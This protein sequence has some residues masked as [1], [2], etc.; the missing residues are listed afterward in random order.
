[1]ILLIES[2]VVHTAV[3]RLTKFER[4][5]VAIAKGKRRLCWHHRQRD[6]LLNNS[7]RPHCIYFHKFPCH[8]SIF[9][10]TRRQAKWSRRVFC[11]HVFR[12]LLRLVVLH[13]WPH[14]QS[15]PIWNSSSRGCGSIRE[16]FAKLRSFG[17]RLG[18][19]NGHVESSTSMYF[20]SFCGWSNCTA[21]PTSNE[22]L[23]WTGRVVI[24]TLSKGPC[25]AAI[26]WC[27]RRQAKWSC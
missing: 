3:Y 18:R 10:C 7:R 25:Q 13:C 15:H 6:S 21:G 27:T 19:Q 22:M 9:W 1:V 5:I 24:A 12:I 16:S 11:I 4:V 20:A 2:I 14:N 17:A 23:Y 8:L 26:F